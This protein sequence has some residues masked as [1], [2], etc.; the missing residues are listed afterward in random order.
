MTLLV[1]YI[2][3]FAMAMAAFLDLLTM[4]LPNRFVIAFAAL[5]FVAAAVI[6][7]PLEAIGMHV[8]A[9]LAMLVIA[10]LMFIPGWIG[11]GDAKFVAACALWLGWVPLMEFA[12][13]AALAGGLMTFAMIASRAY[14]LPAFL[15]R[16]EWALR[17]HRSETGIPYGIAMAIAGIY[18]FPGTIW[19]AALGI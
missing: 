5:F 12:L 11:G 13:I 8:A 9:G 1:A 4:T 16:Q 7:M 17:L 19:A 6:G 18:V 14:P 3:P 2:F 15:S 10:F